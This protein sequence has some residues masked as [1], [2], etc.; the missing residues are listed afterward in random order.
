MGH[1]SSHQLQLLLYFL[2]LPYS[3]SHRTNTAMI[4]P[5]KEV[6]GSEATRW[7]YKLLAVRALPFRVA[8]VRTTEVSTRITKELTIPSVRVA[9]ATSNL[10]DAFISRPRIKNGW[11]GLCISRYPCNLEYL[12]HKPLRVPKLKPLLTKF[13]P[14]SSHANSTFA[15]CNIRSG[16]GTR[17]HTFQ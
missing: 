6:L 14:H 3:S 4:S 8:Q 7:L 15:S 17:M 2:A 11:K 9:R 13:L 5:T 12:H 16:V 1:Q 10:Q